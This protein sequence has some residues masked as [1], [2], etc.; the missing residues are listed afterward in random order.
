MSTFTSMEGYLKTQEFGDTKVHIFSDF[1]AQDP[2]KDFDTPT[3]MV[4][5]HRHY[6]LGNDDHGYTLDDNLPQQ[7]FDD[8]GQGSIVI[9]LYLL[10][11]SGLRMR[12][13]RGF[14]DCDPGHWDSGQAG[15]II[16][17]E[18]A[19]TDEWEGD[20]DRAQGYLYTEVAVYDAWLVGFVYGYV[21]E[22]RFGEHVDSCWGFFDIPPMVHGQKSDF[23]EEVE[24]VG[25][26]W[27]ENTM[28]V[29]KDAFHMA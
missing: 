11:H 24:R 7:L 6:D 2:R 18:Q 22:N 20:R 23:M 12:A 4:C 28:S 3:I 26:W 13:G 9:P 21:V 16:C 19:I 25:T 14:S 10:D 17:P 8:H 5:F 1:D 15:W 27:D 29:P